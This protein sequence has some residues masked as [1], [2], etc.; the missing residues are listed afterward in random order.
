[1]RITHKQKN[2]KAVL[3]L[4]DL[5]RKERE[6]K[7]IGRKGVYFSYLVRRKCWDGMVDQYTNF[8][9]T[10]MNSYII[11]SV[12]CWVENWR[13]KGCIFCFSILAL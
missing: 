3:G 4:G 1:M 12:R 2:T 7:E 13:G 8:S 9:G 5:G 6:G 11:I 10:H